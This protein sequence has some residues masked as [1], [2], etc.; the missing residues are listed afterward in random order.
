MRF[1]MPGFAPFDRAV[2]AATSALV[3]SPTHQLA[4]AVSMAQGKEPNAWDPD[5][6]MEVWRDQIFRV[7]LD[8]ELAAVV[9]Q[10]AA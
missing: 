4:A 6:N 5:A 1:L 7:V 2:D 10:A 9:T 3:G 8:H